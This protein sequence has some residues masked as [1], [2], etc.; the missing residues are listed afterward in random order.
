MAKKEVKKIEVKKEIK[1]EVK[2]KGATTDYGRNPFPIP[3][4]QQYKILFGCVK[5][6]RIR[7][8]MCSPD[9]ERTVMSK[10]VKKPNKIFIDG[11]WYD[12]TSI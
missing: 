12:Y 5:S 9:L 3:M 7:H 6:K 11:F 4:G 1:K 8:H 10:E 2:N